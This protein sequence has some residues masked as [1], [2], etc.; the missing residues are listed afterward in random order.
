MAEVVALQSTIPHLKEL[1]LKNTPIKYRNVHVRV[2]ILQH[3]ASARE[4]LLFL[5]FLSVVEPPHHLCFQSCPEAWLSAPG[6]GQDGL[7]GLKFCAVNKS[8]WGTEQAC[9]MRVLCMYEVIRS[10]NITLTSNQSRR[11]FFSCLFAYLLFGSNINFYMEEEK[12]I[13]AS[14]FQCNF[15]V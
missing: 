6:V 3:L 15:L 13:A 10:Q 12:A 5:S 2:I 9:G 11:G 14:G 4:T 7:Q 8:A 1:I